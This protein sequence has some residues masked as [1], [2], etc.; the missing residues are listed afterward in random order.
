MKKACALRRGGMKKACATPGRP[1]SYVDVLDKHWVLGL[2][3]S[4]PAYKHDMDSSK[5]VDKRDSVD[6][7]CSM[8]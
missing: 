8:V 4:V 5:N 2:R 1:L 7:S 6:N 3:G